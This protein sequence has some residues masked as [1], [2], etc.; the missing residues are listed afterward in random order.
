MQPIPI[1]LPQ[2]RQSYAEG[3]WIFKEIV[4]GIIALR[5]GPAVEESADDEH[6]LDLPVEPDEGMPVIP[7][8]ERVIDVPS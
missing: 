8:D 3:P 5:D 1:R 7:D 2:A 4:M 6:G